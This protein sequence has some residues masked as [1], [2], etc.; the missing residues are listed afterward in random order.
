MTLRPGN[1]EE[2]E[3]TVQAGLIGLDMC[4][5]G[6]FRKGKQASYLVNYRYSTLG[7]LSAIGVDLGDEAISF[8][9][10]AVHLRL[11]FGSGGEVRFFGTG[12]TSQNV[13]EA[14]RDTA[15]WEFDK[16]GSDITYRANTG[17]IGSTARLPIGGSGSLRFTVLLSATEQGRDEVRYGTDLLPMDTLNARVAEQKLSAVTSYDGA[18][19]GRFRFTVGGSVMER[20]FSS[21]FDEAVVGWLLRPYANGRW[22]MTE[23]LDFSLGMALAHFTGI[24]SQALEPRSTIRWR[25]PGAGTLALAGGM[26][27][28]LP[29]YQV[30]GQP[31]IPGIPLV[32]RG[33]LLRSQDIVLGYDHTW[34]DRLSFHVE[35]YQ[36]RLTGLPTT[37]NATGSDVPVGLES[38]VNYWDEVAFDGLANPGTATNQGLEVTVDHSF[39]NSLFYQ[40]NASIYSSRYEL[41]GSWSDTRWNGNYLGNVLGG[42]EFKKE[43]EERLLTWGVTA[44]VSYAGGLR[45][46]PFDVSITGSGYTTNYGEPY[47]AQLND[48]LRCDL[49][50]YRKCDRNGRTG[51]WAIDLQNV[52][53]ARNEA[54]VYF[55]RRKGAPV[56]KYQ[57]G[58]I[59]NISYRIEF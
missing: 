18:I 2:Q 52:A 13:F 11:P 5:E 40:V 4:T 39:A 8:Q 3:W 41:E 47:S 33:E 58:I 55:D 50:V 57:L 30:M 45:Y 34:N 38:T 36:Q 1:D 9:D 7:L 56:T 49:R 20:R 12:G 27:S 29:W 21:V 24:G 54:F 6:P 14:E 37:K 22:Y 53:N 31:V 23:A 26:R 17:A 51:M 48:M 32:E 16:D 19:G 25:I 15:L 35:C 44:R 10:L 28:M 42:A 46:T 43:K 59:P